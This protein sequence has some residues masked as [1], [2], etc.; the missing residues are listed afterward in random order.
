MKLSRTLRLSAAT[1]ALL[2]TSAVSQ[3]ALNV[4]DFVPKNLEVTLSGAY[5]A[6][7][8]ADAEHDFGSA[9]LYSLGAITTYGHENLD[10]AAQWKLLGAIE[11]LNGWLLFGLTTAFLF[12]L[13]QEVSPG[14]H[15]A[16]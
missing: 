4:D 2:A 9:M 6:G 13:F 1:V 3:A 10:L 12:W 8:S 11:A 16:K 15:T 5:L 7:R 14:N